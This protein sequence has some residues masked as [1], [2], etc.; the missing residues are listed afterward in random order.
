[1]KVKSL[2]TD[3][4]NFD[5]KKKDIYMGFTAAQKKRLKIISGA[6]LFVF[7]FIYFI[8]FISKTGER[9]IDQ[10]SVYMADTGRQH[11]EL[12]DAYLERDLCEVKSAAY[13]FEDFSESEEFLK[14]LNEDT[15]FDFVGFFPVI[16]ENEVLPGNQDLSFKDEDF[17]L[18]GLSG[19][20]G[21]FINSLKMA[22]FEAPVYS[23][24]TVAGVIAGF[25]YPTYLEKLTAFKVFG[26]EERCSLFGKDGEPLIRVSNTYN[27]NVIASTAHICQISPEEL[28]NTL[29]E[30]GETSFI[31]TGTN[32]KTCGYIGG[33]KN[34]EWFMEY[35]FPAPATHLIM[36]QS[37]K[38]VFR[39]FMTFAV[40]F[41]LYLLFIVGLEIRESMFI[42]KAL[43]IGEHDELTWL[44]KRRCLDKIFEKFTDDFEETENPFCL[45]MINIDDLAKINEKYGEACGDM[46]MKNIANVV[47]CSIRNGD[48]A[49]RWNGDEFLVLLKTNKELAL[50]VAER[51]RKSIELCQTTF[52]G[53]F[54]TATAT[55]GL[56]EYR[57]DV[58]VESLVEE[59]LGNVKT[60]KSK[61]KNQVISD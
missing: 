15:N 46:V 20:S 11:I 10:N 45:F 43:N 16:G 42:K 27:G 13:F 54:V 39:L 60:G 52:D 5:Y 25:Y 36:A 55:I 31:Y 14:K 61:G 26:F 32:G 23:G 58:P 56:V 24:K 18:Y 35:N 49:F 21:V 29:E 50:R 48:Y 19:K 57:K 6:I 22:V 33:L 12:V 2:K 53:K 1:M 7:V 41:G 4:K 47:I 37:R 44:L 34:A 17:Y 8:V 38:D 28:I 3:R 59:T 40:C 30:D 9:I 51:M